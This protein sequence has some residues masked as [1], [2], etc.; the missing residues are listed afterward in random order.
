MFNKPYFQF[1]RRY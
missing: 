1:T